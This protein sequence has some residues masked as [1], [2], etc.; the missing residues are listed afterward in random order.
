MEFIHG[1][2]TMIDCE[3]VRMDVHTNVQNIPRG[4]ALLSGVGKTGFT[5][6]GVVTCISRQ[7]CECPEQ[8]EVGSNCTYWDVFPIDTTT[9][10]ALAGVFCESL[11][12]FP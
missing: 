12:D 8:A 4:T 7:D 2:E 5:D 1:A 11:G 9:A 10:Q 3:E 6:T